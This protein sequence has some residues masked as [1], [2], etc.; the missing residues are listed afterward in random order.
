MKLV[1]SEFKGEIGGEF[2]DDFRWV[3]PYYMGPGLNNLNILKNVPLSK[4]E[5]FLLLAYFKTVVITLTLRFLE[6]PRN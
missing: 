3:R 2:R 4:H 1:S 6:R 5:L